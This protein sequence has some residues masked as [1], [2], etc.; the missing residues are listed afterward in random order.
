MKLEKIEGQT[1]VREKRYRKADI[2]SIG[3]VLRA[4]WGLTDAQ[5]D[6][7]LRAFFGEEVSYANQ[8]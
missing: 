1:F 4:A 5:V 7:T 8:D 6:E 3:M 2:A